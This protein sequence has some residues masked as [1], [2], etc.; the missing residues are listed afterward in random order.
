[1]KTYAR[2]LFYLTHGIVAITL[3]LSATLL[4]AQCRPG[5]FLVG[6]DEEKYYCETQGSQSEIQDVVQKYQP[7]MLG[8]QWRLRKAIIDAAGCLRRAG[9]RYK[10]GSKMGIPSECS[11][12]HASEEIDC[13]GLTQAASQ[14]AACA[15]NGILRVTSGFDPFG[16]TPRTAADQARI[17]QN[18]GAYRGSRDHPLPG[19]LIF[20][21]RTNPKKS[22][23]THVAVYLGTNASG[24]SYIIHA[25]STAGRV[26]I[27][28][29]SAFLSSRIAGYGDLS[30][31][32]RSV[33]SN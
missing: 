12:S 17:I 21:E 28:K 29:M 2:H 1:M 20:F 3:L 22:G 33:N 5:D 11:I 23:I 9:V 6:E 32:Y 7:E 16:K 26:V 30:A 24:D 8:V 10:Y 14:F 27:G 31:Y 18:H 19:D 13:S 25:S 15:V 4:C